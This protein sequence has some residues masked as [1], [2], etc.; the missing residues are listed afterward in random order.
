SL[1]VG[2]VKAMQL[3]G[4]DAFYRNLVSFGFAR[5][6][7]VDV[8][9]ESA[10]PL[11]AQPDYRL[12]ELATTSFG[13]GIDVNMVQMIAALNVVPNGG[14]WVQPH[15]VERVGGRPTALSQAAPRQV[16]SA[17]TAAQM[18]QMMKSVVQHGS[19]SMARIPGFENDEA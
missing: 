19:G 13:Q 18:N 4:T 2:A 7:G 16:I 9:A 5:P 6:S 15:V 11:R 17:A 1:N 8:D 10:E 14:K 3:E 12:S